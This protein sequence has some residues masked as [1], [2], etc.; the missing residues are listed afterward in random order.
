[1]K[2]GGANPPTGS[3]VT[4][5]SPGYRGYFGH[6]IRQISSAFASLDNDAFERCVSDCAATILSG[7]KVVAT[8]LG[9]NVPICEKFVG[10][11]T[12]L[13]LPA[14]FMNTNSAMH[15]DLGYIQ[16]GDL[17]LMLTKS[18]NTKESISLYE[19]IKHWDCT[20]WLLSFNSGGFLGQRMR[21]RLMLD[22]PHEGDPWNLVPN[23]STS[24]YLIL[25]Q[26]IALHLG[27][28]LDVPL[29]IF[30]N[31]HPGGAIGMKLLEETSE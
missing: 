6:I 25:L 27:E 1:V 26:G 4:I 28:V 23:N 16:N 22:L 17:V 30:R 11:M 31:N 13:G 20:T 14:A 9:K 15:G 8:G 19:H 10:T 2:P 18:G 24:C 3:L 7:H 29:A 21:N 12:S 5:T